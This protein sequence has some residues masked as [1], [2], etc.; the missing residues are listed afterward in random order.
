MQTKTVCPSFVFGIVY[1]CQHHT[2]INVTILHLKGIL[3]VTH[4]IVLVLILTG[5]EILVLILNTIILKPV[6]VLR[7]LDSYTT[8]CTHYKSTSTTSGNRC[9]IQYT[10]SLVH[11]IS[12]YMAPQNNAWPVPKTWTG[13]R[14][15]WCGHTSPR[16]PSPSWA[17]AGWLHAN[18][19]KR[20]ENKYIQPLSI[21]FIWLRSIRTQ[22]RT[23]NCK[24]S[25]WKHSQSAASFSHFGSRQMF[26]FWLQSKLQKSQ[27]L[28]P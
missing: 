20:S 16:A 15:S 10:H 18:R 12:F 9:S 14:A 7:A 5:F 23:A 21:F 13:G 11:D 25:F 3:R 2:G 26:H 22:G 8:S 27:V 19:G 4:E 24:L 1:W 17:S 6:L 28:F